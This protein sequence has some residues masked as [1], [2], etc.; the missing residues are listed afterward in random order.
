MDPEVTDDS[1]HGFFES[2]SFCGSKSTVKSKAVQ[3][4]GFPL[5]STPPKLFL[6][7]PVHNGTFSHFYS[8]WV[9]ALHT[10]GECQFGNVWGGGEWNFVN[11]FIDDKEIRIATYFILCILEASSHRTYTNI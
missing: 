3:L 9:T 8:L 2:T 4:E 7:R 5:A 10:P 11:H 6:R 1:H